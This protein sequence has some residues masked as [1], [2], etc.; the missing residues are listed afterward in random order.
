MRK[1]LPGGYWPDLEPFALLVSSPLSAFRRPVR[2]QDFLSTG[3]WMVVGLENTCLQRIGPTGTLTR[4]SEKQRSVQAW[5]AGD[6]TGWA[7]SFPRV[8]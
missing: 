1:V 7:E 5:M 2:R 8:P 3:N 6:G 4:L